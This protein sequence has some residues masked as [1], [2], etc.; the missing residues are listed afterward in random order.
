MTRKCHA[1]L[2]KWQSSGPSSNHPN[3]DKTNNNLA[4]HQINTT[5][6]AKL[7]THPFGDKE[8]HIKWWMKS[9]I[10]CLRIFVIFDMIAA[11]MPIL[12]KRSFKHALD[13]Q[14][15]TWL[16]GFGVFLS[17]VKR[18]ELSKMLSPASFLHWLVRLV[19]VEVKV[20]QKIKLYKNWKHV[21]FIE[22]AT[23]ITKSFNFPD[24][25]SLS[26]SGIHCI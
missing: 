9:A 16:G 2:V 20:T 17:S 19:A 4:I 1:L 21:S 14:K 12:D 22:L 13:H 23:L 11:A 6:K 18:D 15:I 25:R 10:K 24:W 26:L 3:S 5:C 7:L 8:F